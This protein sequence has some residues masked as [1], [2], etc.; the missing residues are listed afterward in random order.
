MPAPTED[1]QAAPEKCMCRPVLCI[2]CLCVRALSTVSGDHVLV[3]YGAEYCVC[4]CVSGHSVGSV[5][6]C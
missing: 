4:A 5:D 3:Y 1:G 2:M 6:G